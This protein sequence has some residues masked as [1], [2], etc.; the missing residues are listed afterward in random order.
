MHVCNWCAWP[1]PGAL[2][3]VIYIHWLA[4]VCVL[5]YIL[6]QYDH[7]HKYILM[8]FYVK[9]QHEVTYKCEVEKNYT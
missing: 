7:K 3:S 1:H 9:D 6:S 4:K 8:E 2:V 5:F